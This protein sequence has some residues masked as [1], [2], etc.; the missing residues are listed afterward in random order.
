MFD[1]T[2]P[3]QLMRYR[4]IQRKVRVRQF[5]SHYHLD[6]FLRV[7]INEVSYIK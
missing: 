2:L 5:P 7:D 6:I 4:T 1:N 3:L